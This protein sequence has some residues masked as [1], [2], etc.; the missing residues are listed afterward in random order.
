M[1]PRKTLSSKLTNGYLLII[2]NEENFAEKTTFSFN[3]AKLT[4]FL[5]SAFIIFLTLS[6]YLAQTILAQWMDPRYAEMETNRKMLQLV[7]EV[8]S[9]EQMVHQKDVLIANINYIISGEEQS[10]IEDYKLVQDDEKIKNLNQEINLYSLPSID[11]QF[12]KE[13]ED[14][15]FEVVS[16]KGQD[17]RELS[18]IFFFQPI[19]GN[20]S[21]PY[22]AK[23]DHYGVDVVSKKNEPVKSVA[24]GTVIFSS[25]TQDAGNVI[26]IQHRNNLISIYKHNSALLKKMGHFVNAGEIISII[27]NTG[28]LTTGP[29]LHF[30]LWFNG[31]PINPEEFVSF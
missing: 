9:L 6:L 4:V 31:N 13:F 25:W 16:V 8:D 20:V 5:A 19:S 24:D 29:H 3:Y 1:K 14:S 2:R 23:I 21:S 11:S 27:G 7:M 12:R 26:A 30:E 22:N 28:E 18:E 15:G 17:A 10:D